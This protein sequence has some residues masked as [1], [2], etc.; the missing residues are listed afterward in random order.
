MFA[1][2]R[3]G[4]NQY[5]YDRWAALQV[6]RMLLTGPAE[7]T[8]YIEGLEPT[9]APVTV[10]WLCG[11]VFVDLDR[12]ELLYWANQFFGHG[13]MHRYYRALLAERWPGWRT[14]WATSPAG[15]FAAALG[16]AVPELAEARRRATPVVDDGV[17]TGRW[18]ELRASYA[19]R[20]EELAE[21]IAGSGVE[22]V[23]DA[24]EYGS[25]AW[26]TVRGVDGVLYDQRCSTYLW[27]SVLCLGP[28]LVALAK[29][30]GPRP[31]ML[32]PGFERDLRVTLLVDEAARK[33]WLWEAVPGWLSP[34]AHCGALWPGWTV[35]LVDDGARGHAERSGRRFAEI[36]TP[37]EELIT[38]LADQMARTM[39]S[40]FAPLAWLAREAN[41]LQTE[42]PGT[43]VR[44]ETAATSAAV[45]G[46]GA[47]APGVLA[48]LADL[49]DAVDG[50]VDP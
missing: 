7:A 12:R 30:G 5:Y 44:V 3:G 42:S 39:G 6:D 35:E 28:R 50:P 41:R 24:A 38:G 45:V 2:R 19:D 22:A 14:R 32:W 43:T 16:C 17:F 25:D 34:S 13:V 9:D 20:P 31:D 37:R 47:P 49:I 18:D 10:L 1:V 11:A 33:V 15:D 23:R 4:R 46:A 36:R 40:E 21:W 27:A 48:G 8:A 26:V 29:I